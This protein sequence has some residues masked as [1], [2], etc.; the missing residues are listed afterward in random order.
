MSDIL[1]Y[2]VGSTA[3]VH[4]AAAFLA[5][6]NIPVTSSPSEQVTH[7]LLDVPSFDRCGQLRNGEDIES[8]LNSLPR[9]ITVIGGNLDHPALSAYITHDLL[10]QEDYLCHNAAITAH[11]AMRI[12]LPMLTATLP[13]SPV[14]IIGWGRIGKCLARLMKQ[15]G[16]EVRLMIRNPKDRAL[17]L[18]LGYHVLP[19]S[20]DDPDPRQLKVVINTVPQLVL[21]RARLSKYGH[22]IK[23]DLAS[24]PG[25]EG[26]DVTIA[27][28]L[29]GRYA[30]ESSGK[31]IGQ[32]ILNILKEE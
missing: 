23:I 27:G 20:Q 19:P 13:E 28:G 11:C 12:L 31:L 30:P 25:L 29:P 5:S 15:N 26:E 21:D 14:L 3:A 18:A 32:T 6:R 1:F 16:A 22:C 9:D 24:R 2:P 7:L 17:A 8:L 10:K 4:Y